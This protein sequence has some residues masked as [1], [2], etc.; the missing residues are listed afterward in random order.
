MEVQALVVCLVHTAS[1]YFKVL[2]N[3]YAPQSKSMSGT[4]RLEMKTFLSITA[5]VLVACFMADAQQSHAQGFGAAQIRQFQGSASVNRFSTNQIRGQLNNRA[6]GV[7]GVQGVNQRTFAP[8][9]GAKPF[10][11]LNR[12]PSVTPY[13]G[14]SSSFNGVSDYYNIVRPQQEFQRL[15]N[16]QQRTNERT[17]RA[18][19][20]QQHRLNQMAAQ[21]PYDVRGD[22]SIAPTGHGVS[23]M[24]LS[25][26]QQ[27]G[28]Y[29]TPLQ[30]LNK[31]R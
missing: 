24:T 17:Q 4:E 20:A 12:G 29:F 2:R 25:S 14:L 13:L 31:Q 21:A 27:T 7:F 15:R 26:F 16:Q 28:N 18:L 10:Q 6:V 30:G 23:Y 8:S 1:L 22:A 19:V 5:L 3:L 11:G 9:S